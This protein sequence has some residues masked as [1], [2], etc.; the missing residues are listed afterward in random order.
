M[1]WRRGSSTRTPG[2]LYRSLILPYP[3]VSYLLALPCF[4]LVTKEAPPEGRPVVCYQARLVVHPPNLAAEV[5]GSAGCRIDGRPRG[6][7]RAGA[8]A[9][10][11]QGYGGARV[12]VLV[13]GR[14]VTL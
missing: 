14:Y 11:G 1:R 12:G 13:H 5:L 2:N 8:R 4:G 10:G 9:V 6:G 3:S 7:P